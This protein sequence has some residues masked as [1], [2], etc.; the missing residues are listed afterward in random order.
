M[1]NSNR[2][3][4]LFQFLHPNRPALE[5]KHNSPSV[6]FQYDQPTSHVAFLPYS[7]MISYRK[8]LL[9]ISNNVS[10]CYTRRLQ[11]IHSSIR[12]DYRL[13]H[14]RLSQNGPSFMPAYCKVPFCMTAYYIST[15][16]YVTPP[17]L[18]AQRSAT[19]RNYD[20]KKWD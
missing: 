4:H 19:T 5:T 9:T 8:R 12:N 3:F 13:R 16:L 18:A 17:S 1:N 2:L 7:C 10:L 11:F 20:L 6:F 15:R 14:P